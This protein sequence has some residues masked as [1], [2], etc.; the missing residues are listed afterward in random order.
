MFPTLPFR[1]RNDAG[2]LNS[3]AALLYLKEAEAVQP[4]ALVADVSFLNRDDL[5]CI[6]RRVALEERVRLREE[7]NQRRAAACQASRSRGG[8]GG[9][10]AEVGGGGERGAEDRSKATA[11]EKRQVRASRRASAKTLDAILRMK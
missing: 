2:S 1:A 5:V 11:G 9:G 8:G 6:Q 7:A 4:C 10:G 3:K